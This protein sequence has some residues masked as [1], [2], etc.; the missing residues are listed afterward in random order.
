[1]NAK[2]GAVSVTGGTLNVDW[3]LGVHVVDKDTPSFNIGSATTTISE[4]TGSSTVW[5]MESGDWG[6]A[7]T[8]WWT[9]TYATGT[10]T[11]TT[12]QPPDD[13]AIRIREYSQD[14]A[15]T[16][17]YKYNLAIDPAA[18]FVAYDYY[19]DYDNNYL[20]STSSPETE[21]VDKVIGEDWHRVNISQMNTPYSCPG[22][23]GD[24]CINEPPTNGSWYAGMSSD[25]QFSLTPGALTLELREIYDWT[26][27]GTITLYATTSYTGGYTI[28]AYATNAG[29]LKLG[30]T[31]NYIEKWDYVNTTPAYWNYKCIDPE[32]ECG[33]GY[34]TSDTWLY[35]ASSTDYDNRFATSTKYAGFIGDEPGD[36]VADSEE[37]VYATTTTITLKASVDPNYQLAGSYTGTI[38]FIAT[39]NY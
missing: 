31:E 29:K 38:Y 6:T 26:A 36:P 12:P 25:L 15:T 33:F 32:N 8:S 24:Q 16:T 1:L 2:T 20:T 37:P 3:Y 5:K 23:S 21:N 19:L 17:Y 34:T 11:G 14:S 4:A 39:V 18:G 30:E 22:G 13:G 27:T 9:I 28:T 10:A 35:N 7:S